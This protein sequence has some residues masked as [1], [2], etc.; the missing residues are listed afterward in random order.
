MERERERQEG[1]AV[2]FMKRDQ[3]IL[4]DSVVMREAR[5]EAEKKEEEIMT[6]DVG[7]TDELWTMTTALMQRRERD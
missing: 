2:R 5:M 7:E 6:S 1:N 3:D 4:G